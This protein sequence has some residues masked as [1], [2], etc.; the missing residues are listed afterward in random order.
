MVDAS[1]IE[2]ERRIVFSRKTAVVGHGLSQSSREDRL[3][4][5]F[6]EHPPFGWPV[7][8]ACR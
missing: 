6:Q 4:L 5:A 1:S 8:D 2:G 7:F 3:R